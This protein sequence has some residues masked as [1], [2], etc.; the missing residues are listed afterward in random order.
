MQLTTGN[1]LT[2]NA[3]LPEQA[4]VTQQ[5]NKSSLAAKTETEVSLTKAKDSDST[6]A[7][8]PNVEKSD[9]L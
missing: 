1:Y 4:D 2:E 7:K 3:T 6:L 9:K 5:A 8:K